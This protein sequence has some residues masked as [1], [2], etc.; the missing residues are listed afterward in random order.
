MLAHE[1]RR[2]PVLL[3]RLCCAHK[4]VFRLLRDERLTVCRRDG[5]KRA[6]GT[7]VPMLVA[8]LLNDRRSTSP[9]TSSAIARACAS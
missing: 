5:R 3:R 6:L 8:Q 4:H 1:R 7:R 9:A 2:V